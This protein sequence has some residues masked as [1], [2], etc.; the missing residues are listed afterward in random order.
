[1]KRHATNRRTGVPGISAPR[2]GGTPPISNAGQ[3]RSHS[4]AGRPA[5]RQSGHVPRPMRACRAH[6]HTGTPPRHALASTTLST[7][8]LSTGC[9]WGLPAEPVALP[10][11]GNV[12]LNAKYYKKIVF[13]RRAKRCTI[14]TCGSQLKSC[15]RSGCFWAHCSS[16]KGRQH[17]LRQLEWRLAKMLRA[18]DAR[19]LVLTKA[20]GEDIKVAA[21]RWPAARLKFQKNFLKMLEI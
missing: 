5:L 1:M 15:N 11:I 18:V 16:Q 14:N 19:R 2:C 21:S 13:Y 4:G 10:Y 7:V 20:S 3:S 17:R 8:L 9:Q 6:P 12:Y